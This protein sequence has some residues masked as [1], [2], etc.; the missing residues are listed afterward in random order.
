MVLARQAAVRV[1]GEGI[2]WKRLARLADAV[3]AESS[4]MGFTQYPGDSFTRVRVV[5]SL[6]KAL[7]KR[8]RGLGA[9]SRNS[10]NNSRKKVPETRYY[11]LPEGHPLGE[12]KGKAEGVGLAEHFIMACGLGASEPKDKA[13]GQCAILQEH[14]V[15]VPNPDYEKP[16][17][18][19][20]EETARAIIEHDDSLELLYYVTSPRVVPGLSSWV[21]DPMLVWFSWVPG[22]EFACAAGDSESKGHYRFGQDGSLFL[23]ARL[24]D[25]VKRNRLPLS[26]STD[27][28][29]TT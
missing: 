17:K 9:C 24:A 15:A 26:T 10:N 7:S 22:H 19:I 12:L 1:G 29:A 27:C 8:G 6:K 3:T 20:Y 25:R 28:L 5:S 2:D 14:G 13:Y 18:T 4:V 16:L 11:R 21:P 23:K